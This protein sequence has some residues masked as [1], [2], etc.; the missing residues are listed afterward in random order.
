MKAELASGEIITLKKG[1]ECAVHNEPHWV[2][3]DR[4]SRELSRKLIDPEGK[5]AEQRYY[6]LLGRAK[7]EAARLDQKLRMMNSL[8]I[9]RLIA[10]P[11]DELTDIQRQ[12]IKQ[13]YESMLPKAPAPIAPEF[14]DRETQVRIEAKERL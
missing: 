4:V 1:C 9:V 5:T 2:Y 6:G 7:E 11:S 8:G 13:N 12:Q 3:M 10:E 14:L